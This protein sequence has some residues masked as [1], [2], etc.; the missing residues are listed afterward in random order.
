MIQQEATTNFHDKRVILLVLPPGWEG[1]LSNRRETLTAY[2]ALTGSTVG[3][4]PDGPDGVI[5]T[6]RAPR[7]GE[8]LLVEYCE[9]GSTLIQI[10]GNLGRPRERKRLVEH[11]KPSSSLCV[12]HTPV[13]EHWVT[14]IIPGPEM[15]VNCADLYQ[16]LVENSLLYPTHC[17][18]TARVATGSPTLA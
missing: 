18:S 15:S 17:A 6:V 16:E 9:P 7:D 12:L 3:E 10:F 14:S 5:A 1:G 11:L 8:G 13:P 2:R 4:M